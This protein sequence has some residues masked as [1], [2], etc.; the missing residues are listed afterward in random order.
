MSE[1]WRKLDTWGIIFMHSNKLSEFICP[2]ARS[3]NHY[4]RYNLRCP[5]SR[6]R[7]HVS[8]LNATNSTRWR[9]DQTFHACVIQRQ[10]SLT[11]SFSDHAQ[12]QPCVVG[13]RVEIAV[14]S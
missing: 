10:T 2:G 14:A 12:Y 1:P 8:Q 3:V 7:I 6:V 9:M 13:F 5:S 11:D 4:T